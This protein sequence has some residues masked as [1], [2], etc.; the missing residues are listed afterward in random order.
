MSTEMI[1][2][3]LAKFEAAAVNP[4]KQLE[5]YLSQGK[6]AI[7]CFPYYV[8]EELVHA[9]G[10]VPFGL[11]GSNTKAIEAAKEYFATFYCSLAQLNLEMG[12][13]GTLDGLSGVIV[14]TLCDTLRPLS[15]NFRVAVPQ[16]PFIFLAHPQNRRKEYGVQY[17]MAQYGNVKGKLEDISGKSITD[18]ELNQSIR[19]YNKSRQARREF[20]RLAGEHPELISA[21]QRSAVLKSAYFMLKED[22]TDLLEQLNAGLQ[23]APPAAWKGIRIMTSGIVAD[24][25]GLLKILEEN[26]MVIVADDVAHES[27][28]FRVDAAEDGDPMR[29]LALQFAAQDHDTILYDPELNKRPEYLVKAAREAGAEGVIVLMM[30]FCDPEEMEYPSLKRGLSEAGILHIMIGI[31]QQMNDFGQARTQI[32]AFADVLG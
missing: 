32:Q 10:M 12:L 19:V 11:W 5:Q 31:D 20:V 23:A 17:T 29:A 15:Q 14:T 13:D 16:I 30:Q 27:R 6:K 22:H 9:A 8:P 1:Q 7:G 25:P 18:G 28:G 2:E 21:S 3:L 26:Q 24:D 4:R